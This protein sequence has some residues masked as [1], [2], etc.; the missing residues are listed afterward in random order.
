MPY[1][2]T[3]VTTQLTNFMKQS[4]FEKPV[5]TQ[6][7]QVCTAFC[8]IFRLITVTPVF[9]FQAFLPKINMQFSPMHTTCPVHLSLPDVTFL[10][11]F[12]L[13]I[14]YEVLYYAVVS[15]RVSVPLF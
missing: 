14:N 12:G 4:N 1:K 13:C 8:G 3:V 2:I 7:L 5:V 6:L 11:E 15:S 9:F 10:I